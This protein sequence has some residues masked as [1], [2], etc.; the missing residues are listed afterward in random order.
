MTKAD[1]TV[2]SVQRKL[3]SILEVRVKSPYGQGSKT[4]RVE[5]PGRLA[6]KRK[7]AGGCEA[8]VRQIINEFRESGDRGDESRQVSRQKTN[9]DVQ[10]SGCAVQMACKTGKHEAAKVAS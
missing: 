5:S 10:L 3:C 6:G 8:K 9:C 7:L 2:L 1:E 4:E